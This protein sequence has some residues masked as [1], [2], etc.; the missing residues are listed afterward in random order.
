MKT[1]KI[2]KAGSTVALT[3]AATLLAAGMARSA[4]PQ[5][6]Q[7]SLKD[8]SWSMQFRINENFALSSF[9]GSAAMDSL[10]NQR[11]CNRFSVHQQ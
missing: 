5:Q 3:V 2:F 10:Q 4:E 7:N 9:E 8:G 11:H 6:V 1:Q